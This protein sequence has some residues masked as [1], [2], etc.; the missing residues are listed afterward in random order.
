MHHA[1][2]LREPTQLCWEFDLGWIQDLMRTGNAPLRS[3]GELSRSLLADP[4]WPKDVKIKARSLAALIS[5]LDREQELD[6][7]SDRPEVRH[8]L[9]RS[10]KCSVSEL[11]DRPASRGAP[12]RLLRWTDLPYARTLELTREPLP[13]GLPPAAT[14]PGSWS[15]TWWVAGPGAGKSLAGEWLRARGLARF[16]RARTPTELASLSD[17]AAF[18]ELEDASLA[19]AIPERLQRLCVASPCWPRAERWNVL[20]SPPLEA[21]LPEL[22]QYALER[23]SDDSE[24]EPEELSNWLAEGPVAKREVTSVGAVLGLVGVADEHGLKDLTRKGLLESARSFVRAR[25]EQAL[26]EEARALG[27]LRRNGFELLVSLA[28]RALTDDSKPIYGARSFEEWVALVP[29]EHQSSLDVEWLSLS[30]ASVDSSIRPSDI[31][32]AAR[33]LSPGAYRIARTLRTARL[34]EPSDG[35]RLTLAPR[36]IVHLAEREAER[37][38]LGASAF[39]WGEALLRP[40]AADSVPAALLARLEAGDPS[41][42]G[43]VLEHESNESPALAAAIEA[44]FRVAGHGLLRGMEIDLELLADLFRAATELAVVLPPSGILP[45]IEHAQSVDAVL[46][47]GGYFLAAWAISE[48]LGARARGAPALLAP[49][50]TP[51]DPAELALA[52]DAIELT[53][54]STHGSKRPIDVA[55]YALVDRLRRALDRRAP[56]LHSLELPGEVAQAARENRLDWSLVTGLSRRCAEALPELVGGLDAAELARSLAEAWEN[57]ERPALVGSAL[58]PTTAAGRRLLA[59]APESVVRDALS[60]AGS[61]ADSLAALLPLAFFESHAKLSEPEPT[62]SAALA[63]SLPLD[64]VDKWLSHATLSGLVWL[65]HPERA[66]ESLARALDRAEFEHAVS[67]VEAA[68]P[69]ER[70]QVL[71]ALEKAPVERLSGGARTRLRRWLH[72]EVAERSKTFRDAFALLAALDA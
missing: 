71:A 22:V 58:D 19:D 20:T 36:W 9:A 25:I 3:F 67:L 55:S 66:R 38:L 13:P 53:L 48:A 14:D 35:D 65:R 33:R 27:W 46:S 49:W 50:L 31:E 21:V 62:V 54:E 56:A 11:A 59:R 42:L 63:R 24:L 26:G 72:A 16:V 37:Q 7:L 69:I 8:V 34:L 32:R 10:L 51:P 43:D 2:L 28:R 29:A 40:H 15:R 4:G 60:H 41:P 23:L 12:S 6:W 57:A 64:A 17:G 1:I 61:H 70:A 5:K 47:R 52:Y 39:E 30:L 45:R 44:A 68:P 18:I